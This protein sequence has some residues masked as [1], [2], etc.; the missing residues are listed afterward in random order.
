[1][2]AMD[3]SEVNSKASNQP[4]IQLLLDDLCKSIYKDVNAPK[5]VIAHSL[6]QPSGQQKCDTIP[7]DLLKK[8]KKNA[9]EILLTKSN[10]KSLSASRSSIDEGYCE[11]IDP[12]RELQFSQFE[13]SI[14]VGEMRPHFGPYGFI[15]DREEKKIMEKLALFKE[16]VQLVDGNDY[17]CNDQSDGYAILWFL[18]LLKNKSNIDPLLTVVPYFSLALDQVPSF[19][20]MQNKYFK[21]NWQPKMELVQNP[22]CGAM[23]KLNRKT[24]LFHLPGLMNEASRG[25]NLE[26]PKN[27]VEEVLDNVRSRIRP[28]NIYYEC[29]RWEHQGLRI[30]LNKDTDPEVIASLYEKKFCSELSDAPLNVLAITAAKQQQ[31]FRARIV[32]KKLFNEHIKLLL[33]G[34]ES[35]SFIFDAN[36]ITFSLLEN[37]TVE[38]IMPEIL[39]NFVLDFIECGSCYKRL[40]SLIITNNFQLKYNG[41]VF[42]VCLNSNL[43][44]FVTFYNDC[45]LF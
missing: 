36:T 19:P 34:V 35:E 6:Y 23:R 22:Y 11:V 18:T 39:A 40:K 38:N 13:Y 28:S 29:N 27:F 7:E 2:I 20:V 21:L 37:L 1:M 32:D 15:R 5:D 4:S 33:I 30:P 43:T 45:L 44:I 25:E 9:F 16:C 17:F 12:A 26:T 14:F 42:K 3:R 31:R 24:N 8:C 41:F 10:V